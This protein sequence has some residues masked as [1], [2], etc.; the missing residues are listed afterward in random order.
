[1]NKNFFK[2]KSILITGGT[3][4]FGKALVSHLLNNKY[5]L[6]KIVIFS[7]DEL[8]QFEMSQDLSIEKFTSLRYFRLNRNFSQKIYI[9]FLSNFFSTIFAK[10]IFFFII[11]F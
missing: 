5:Q 6:K 9:H 4:S 11:N 7:R 3:G 8:K 10:N 2:N 1:M